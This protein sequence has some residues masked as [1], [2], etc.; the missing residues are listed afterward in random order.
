ML[1]DND[2]DVQT[3]LD[4]LESIEASIEVKVQ[5]T[6]YIDRNLQGY[7]NALETEI[8]R[9]EAKKRA[10]DNQIERLRNNLFNCLENAG[11]TEVKT[12]IASIKLQNNP[13]SVEIIN[14]KIIPS[15]Y[16]TVIPES[17]KPRKAD[18]AKDLKSGIKVSGCELRQTRRWVVK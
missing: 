8:T 14:E 7:S 1:E 15:Q 12:D 4:T 3:L 6:I 18:I 10:V 13:V 11:L 17:Y 16:L 2:C 5:N 9:L